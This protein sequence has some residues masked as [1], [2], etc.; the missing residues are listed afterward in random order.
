MRCASSGAIAVTF[1]GP[2]VPSARLAALLAARLALRKRAA[3]AWCARLHVDH[4]KR[5]RLYPFGSAIAITRRRTSGTVGGIRSRSPF[6]GLPSSSAARRVTARKA[7]TSRLRVTW[8][9]L[10]ALSARDARGF[11]EHSGYCSMGQPF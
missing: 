8:R 3:T 9:C 7:W 2:S 10:D 1:G 6:L 5:K 11:F 4:P